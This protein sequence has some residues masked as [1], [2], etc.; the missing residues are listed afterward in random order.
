MRR[1][2]KEKIKT[3]RIL[4]GLLYHELCHGEFAC[5][6]MWHIGY[7]R[8]EYAVRIKWLKKAIEELNYDDGFRNIPKMDALIAATKQILLDVE[9]LK[10][11]NEFEVLG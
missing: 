2:K 8:I 10:K 5:E 11:K 3:S 9:E 6:E 1:E 7:M 4:L